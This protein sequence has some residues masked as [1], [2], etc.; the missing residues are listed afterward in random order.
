MNSKLSV[1]I[2]VYNHL[3][4][5]NRCCIILRVQLCRFFDFIKLK[6]QGQFVLKGLEKHLNYIDFFQFKSIMI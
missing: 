5:E 4:L 2:N 6:Y 3:G 1:H